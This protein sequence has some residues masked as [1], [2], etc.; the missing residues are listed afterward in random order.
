[1]R[2]KGSSRGETWNRF[3]IYQGLEILW[4]RCS[5]LTYMRHPSPVPF[6]REC[7]PTLKVDL[8]KAME[9]LHRGSIGLIK[10][11]LFGRRPLLG[12]CAGDFYYTTRE[13][14]YADNHRAALSFGISSR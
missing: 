4:S 1:M 7:G 13:H 5:A 2:I 10:K 11:L 3:F 6:I 9:L 12:R 14:R 8:N